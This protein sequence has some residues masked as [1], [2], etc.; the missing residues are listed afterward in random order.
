M[1]Y[2]LL[3]ISFLMLRVPWGDDD[4]DMAYRDDYFTIY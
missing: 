3:L 2:C 1:G 4:D